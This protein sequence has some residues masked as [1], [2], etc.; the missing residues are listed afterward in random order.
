MRSPPGLG[1]MI[2]PRLRTGLTKSKPNVLKLQV[3]ISWIFRGTPAV[4]QSPETAI[5]RIRDTC[6]A[7]KT[8]TIAWLTGLIYFSTFSPTRAPH[9]GNESRH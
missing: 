7:N 6:L 3:G 9:G 5:V 8:M 1:M 4:S 2:L